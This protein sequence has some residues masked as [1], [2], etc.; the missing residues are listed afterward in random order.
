MP[1]VCVFGHVLEA[2]DVRRL[3]GGIGYKRDGRDRSSSQAREGRNEDSSSG[4]RWALRWN[5]DG[6]NVSDAN[7]YN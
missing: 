5:N 7:R 2:S 4:K 6:E 3:Q 1:L